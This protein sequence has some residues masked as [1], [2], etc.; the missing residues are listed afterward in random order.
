MRTTVSPGTPAFC[1]SVPLAFCHRGR[2]LGG[3]PDNDE[4]E[5][6]RYDELRHDAGVEPVTCL[7]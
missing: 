2:A 1:R 4:K 5:K 3:G 6:E 7:G